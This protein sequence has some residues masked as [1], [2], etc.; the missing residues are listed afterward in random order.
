MAEARRLIVIDDEK[1]FAAFVVDVA[2]GLGYEAVAADNAH[3]FR[4][5]Y[6]VGIPDVV[7]SDIVMP[8]TDGIEIIRW[9]MEQNARAR[10]LIASGYG[11]A[12]AGAAK[13]LGESQGKLSITIMAK[14]VK[15]AALRD[16]LYPIKRKDS[17]AA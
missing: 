12:Y 15:A 13:M 11:L 3:A 4:E 2:K 14:P 6:A 1:E 8:G 10:I 7:V 17:S 16:F 5:L 9:L